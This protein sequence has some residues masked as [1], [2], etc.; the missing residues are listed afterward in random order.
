MKKFMFVLFFFLSVSFLAAEE[1]DLLKNATLN[2]F[3]YYLDDHGKKEDCFK[4]TADGILQLTGSP[5]GWLGTKKSYKNYTLTA[6][7][8]YPDKSVPTNSGFL[9]RILSQGSTFLPKCLELQLQPGETGDLYGFHDFVFRGEQERMSSGKNHEFAGNY[10]KSLRYCDCENAKEKVWNK[11]EATCFEDLFIVRL[12]GHIMNWAYG[13]PNQTGKFAFQ[14]EGGPIWFRN[15]IIKTE[16]EA[17][18]ANNPSTSEED[19]NIERF[20]QQSKRMEQ[21]NVDLLMIGDSI[22]HFWENAGKEVWK[23]YYDHR[24]AMNFGISADRTGHLL[25]RIHHSPMNKI[26]PKMAVI[27]IGTNNVGHKKSTPVQTVEGIKLVVSELQK[28]YPDMKILLLEVFPRDAKS[29]GYFRRKV[30]EINEGLRTAF[31]NEKNVELFRT[32]DLFLDKDGNLPKDLMPD[33]LHPSARGYEIWA[34]AIE[35]KIRA[36]FGE[37]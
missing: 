12:N 14:S 10:V 18:S 25:W 6:E 1:I 13:V 36:A 32:D 22:T 34:K 30:N 19:R 3:D 31:V 17:E 33:Y 9:F 28:L 21:G 8:C 35:P 37:K 5:K 23:K 15:V 11:I 7:Y 4:I 29:D 27:L 20:K 2:D 16:N 24:N 26:S